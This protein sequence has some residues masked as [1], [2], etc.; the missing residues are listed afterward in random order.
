MTTVG[1]LAVQGDV[2]A[3]ARALARVGVAARRVLRA[4]EIAACDG[5]ILPGGES[6]T[7]SKGM[8]RLSLWEPLRAFAKTGRPVLGTCAGAILLSREARSPY[9][10]SEPVPTLGILDVVACRN[11]YGTQVDSFRAPVD[12]DSDPGLLGFPCVFIRA[13]RLEALGAEV[14]VLARVD[15]EPVAVRQGAVWA[16]TFHPELTDDARLHEAW[17]G[18]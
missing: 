3:H 18:A 9:S 13:P 6:T 2:E 8:D 14:E 10:G 5:V 16:T 12:P 1:I 7:I 15:R 4:D 11:A 17:L